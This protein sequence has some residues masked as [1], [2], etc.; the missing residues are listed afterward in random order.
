MFGYRL[1][2]TLG[3]LAALGL[4][5]C[6]TTADLT[7]A[8][9]SQAVS[10][11]EDAAR[12]ELNGVSMLVQ[13]TEW[14]GQAPV[15]TEVTPLRVVIE[16]NSDRPLRVVY[17]EFALVG[18]DGVISSALPLYE[19]DGSIAEPNEGI[20]TPLAENPGFIHSGF[21]VAPYLHGYYPTMR[22]A[23]APFYHDNYYYTSH[24]QHW[25]TTQ[26]PTQAMRDNALPEGVLS[27]GGRLEGWLYFEPV[28]DASRVVF[29]ADLVDARNGDEFGEIR[30]PFDVN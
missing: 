28:G 9:G 11:L 1:C 26:L 15:Q 30:V 12:T 6:S 17:N 3:V 20:V 23:A 27:S 18:P 2:H 8:S 16:N 22:P 4:T 7:P 24:L 19:I 29:R 10:A 13:S 5:G 25:E 21:A 14:P